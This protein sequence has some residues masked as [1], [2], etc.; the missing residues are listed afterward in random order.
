[1]L[2][3][4]AALG[5]ACASRGRLIMRKGRRPVPVTRIVTR[6]PQAFFA[7]SGT[8]ELS[9]PTAAVFVSALAVPIPAEPEALS[10]SARSGDCLWI[11]SRRYLGTGFRWPE[12]ARANHMDQPWRIEVGQVL[13][14]PAPPPRPAGARLERSRPVSEGRRYGWAKVPNDAFT[15]GE[16]LTFAVQYGSVTAGYA[17]LS[18][19]EVVEYNGRPAFHVVAEARTHPF[20]E[21]FFKVHDVLTSYID[22]DYAF[23]WRYEKHIHEGGFKADAS[24]E[25]DHRDCA[26]REPAKG[27][28]AEMPEDSQDVLSCFYYFRT[29]PMVVGSVVTIP[30]TADD[31]KSYG[32]TV[33]VLRKESISTLAGDFDCVVVQPHLT[34]QGVFQQKGEVTIWLTDDQRRIPV[35]VKSKIAI[36]SITV[37]L[38]DAEWVEPE[39]GAADE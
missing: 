34:F 16:K 30:V 22:V 28:S 35:L 6:T 9:S 24:Y 31:M 4:L 21:T 3:L 1:M 5:T 27:T 29:Q 8:A 33:N 36:G 18:I 39:H 23:P 19:P 37:N 12:I 20:F 14:M 11:L 13:E 32:L 26:I 10:V 17:T 15:V 2:A 25:Y 7:V 38:Q